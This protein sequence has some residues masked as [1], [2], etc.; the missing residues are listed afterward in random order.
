MT[1]AEQAAWLARAAAVSTKVVDFAT[2]NFPDLGLTADR[3]RAD[4]GAVEQRGKN[5]LAFTERSHGH[6]VAVFGFSFVQA[7]EAN[8]AYVLGIVAHELYG[9][10]EYGGSASGYHMALYDEAQTNIEGYEKP[11][12]GSDER[13]TE[14]DAYGY[15]ETEIYSILREVPY[16]TPTARKDKALG[17]KNSDP[18]RRVAYRLQQMKKQWAPSLIGPLLR[19]LY[20][21]LMMDPRITPEAIQAF[22]DGIEEI[23]S[24]VPDVPKQVLK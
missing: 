6:P 17:I 10:Q 11:E 21:R 5:V 3:L 13:Q 1:D 8:P 22:R 7:A 18:R 14:T 24:D 9:H 4:F 20:Q 16:Y 12:P 2:K 23:F 15:Q 19:G